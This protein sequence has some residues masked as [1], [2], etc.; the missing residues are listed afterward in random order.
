VFSQQTVKKALDRLCS[1]LLPISY[2]PILMNEIGNKANKQER[3][4]SGGERY[5]AVKIRFKS[6]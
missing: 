4:A 2:S 3:D 1:P 6:A 5:K